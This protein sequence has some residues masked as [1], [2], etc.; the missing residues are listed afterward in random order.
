VNWLN[1]RFSGPESSPGFLLWKVSTLWRR[2]VE[3]ALSQLDLTH[4]Q[5][6]LLANIGWLTRDGAEIRQVELAQHC[7]MDV[8]STS[9][10][11]RMLERKGQIERYHLQ[12][13]ERSKFLRL[14][15]EGAKLVKKA[16]PIVEEVDR[17]FFK[18]VD[19]EVVNRAAARL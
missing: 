17:N 11:L 5:F 4:P 15:K 1:S 6:V 18:S 14:T 8:N 16:L 9:Q 19:I 7:S 13:D 10:I 2:E 3:G 12:E